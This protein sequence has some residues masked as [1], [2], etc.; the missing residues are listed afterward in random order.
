[1]PTTEP[2]LSVKRLWLAGIDLRFELKK[3]MIRLLYL[4]H[5]RGNPYGPGFLNTDETS[6]ASYT[7][8]SRGF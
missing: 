3:R 5:E 4:V 2:G 8:P 1:M 6:V 7:K